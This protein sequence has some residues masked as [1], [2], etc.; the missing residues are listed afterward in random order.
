MN[1]GKR[2]LTLNMKHDEGRQ[3]ARRLIAQSDIVVENFSTGVM[4]RLGLGY[5]DLR[6][7][8]PKII[9]ASLSSAGRTGPDREVRAYG[10]LIQC[11]TG[12]AGLS[13]YPDR[14]PQTPGGVW[15][16]PL[17]ALLLADVVLAAV[18]RQ[19]RTGE[20][21][22]IDLSMVEA[23]ITSIPEP[24]LA[25]TMNGVDV[26]PRANR[27]PRSAP[28][29]CYRSDGDDTWLAVTV[30]T[31]AEWAALCGVLGRDD[32]ASDAALATAEGR[33]QQHD[34]IDAAIADW[35]RVRT[36]DQAAAELQAVG[37][38][39]APSLNPIDAL[40]DPHLVAR[41]VFGEIPKLEGG[42]RMAPRVPWLINGIRPDQLGRPP[43]VGQHNVPILREVLRLPEH[44]VERLIAE[45]AVY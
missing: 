23:T 6:A 31:D 34:R 25:W 18:W 1:P 2:S 30:R 44:D 16:D 5:E 9:M 41:G 20:G 36:A 3:I 42:T 27:D 15:T 14:A 21:C 7:L 11:F 26:E 32:L 8:N 37:I 17:A 33:R 43:E 19:R 10:T 35:A 24:M 38:G 39:A 40:T 29:G 28:Q 13:R 12:W 4:E 22:A 45:Q